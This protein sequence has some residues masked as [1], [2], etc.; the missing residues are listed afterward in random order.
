MR[1]MLFLLL[2]ALLPGLAHAQ[3]ASASRHFKVREPRE[4]HYVIEL[5]A[6]RS[7]PAWIKAKGVGDESVEFG[8]RVV[9]QIETNI[10]LSQLVA[11]S[12]LSKPQPVAPNIFLLEA[13][14]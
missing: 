14:D 1:S 2:L 3:P 5:P 7:R 9:L 8:S 12:R 11:G 10:N 13:P 6:G 4:R